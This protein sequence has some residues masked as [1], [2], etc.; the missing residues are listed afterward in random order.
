MGRLKYLF[1]FTL[2]ALA[3]ISFHSTGWKAYLPVMEAFA[4]IPLLELLF[5]PD[6][7]NLSSERKETMVSDTFYKVVL[8]LCVPIQLVMG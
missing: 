3:L 5:T 4:L 7:K 6:A 1:V 8:R 2:P